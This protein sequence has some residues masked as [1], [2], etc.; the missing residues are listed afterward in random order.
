M[1]LLKDLSTPMNLQ[2]PIIMKIFFSEELTREECVEHFQN[3]KNEYLQYWQ[4]LSSATGAISHYCKIF[5]S[6]EKAEYWE[7][8][9]DGQRGRDPSGLHHLEVYPCTISLFPVC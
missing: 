3:M 1:R 4:H 6:A 9:P 2:I 7:M 5:D 8:T